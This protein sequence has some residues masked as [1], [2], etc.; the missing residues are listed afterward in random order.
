MP[1]SP[2]PSP[3]AA[4]PPGAATPADVLAFW[5]GASPPTDAAAL[6]AQP[7]WFTKSEAFD[8][9]VRAR[10]GATI[11][12][13]LAGRLD[14]WAHEPLGWLALTV[15]LDQF[16]RNVFRGTARSFAG[17]AQA[18]AL[19]LQGLARGWDGELPWLARPFVLLPLEHSEDAALQDDCVA[20]FTALCAQAQAEGVAEPLRQTLAGNLD[21]AERHREVIRRFG[22]FPHRNAALGRSST[23]AEQAYLAQPGAGF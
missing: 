14:G 21:Y 15:V 6:A 16:T 23:P 12:A 1:Q 4:A 17:D 3:P 9:Q 18:R 5:F 7:R 20:R 8:A 19:A 22:R 11:E 10:F 13:A 2:P